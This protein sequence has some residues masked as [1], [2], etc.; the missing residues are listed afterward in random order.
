MVFQLFAFFFVGS[1]EN[2]PHYFHFYV[3]KRLAEMA[4]KPKEGGW[5]VV[6]EHSASLCAWS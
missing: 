6:L 3:Y 2:V 1:V 5:V 4:G